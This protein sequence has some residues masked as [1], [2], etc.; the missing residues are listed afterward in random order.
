MVV[1]RVGLQR[2]RDDFD[3]ERP[4]KIIML[5]G[6]KIPQQNIRP[7]LFEEWITPSIG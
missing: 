6:N 2:A 3:E 7:R 4:T 5:F 1:V